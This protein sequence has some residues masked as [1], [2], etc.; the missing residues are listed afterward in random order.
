MSVQILFDRFDPTKLEKQLVWPAGKLSSSSIFEMTLLR[1]TRPFNFFSPCQNWINKS[2]FIFFGPQG[3]VGQVRQDHFPPWGVMMVIT[4][5][6][7]T[8][9]INPLAHVFFLS[10]TL[11]SADGSVHT[12]A[13][14]KLR[15]FKQTELLSPKDTLSL[16]GCSRNFSI[17]D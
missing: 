2:C 7:I 8:N 11:V 13:F 10:K 3:W 12:V 4:C 14:K 5:R 17:N 9:K 1:N 15:V 16:L 6:C